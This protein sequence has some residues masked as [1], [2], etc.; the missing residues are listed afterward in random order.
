DGFNH[1]QRDEL[2]ALFDVT[3]SALYSMLQFRKTVIDKHQVQQE[4]KLASLGKLAAGVAHEIN[5]PLGFVMSNFSFL[6]EYVAQ[7]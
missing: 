2:Y 5:N 7:I 4:E 1:S 6:N 3:K